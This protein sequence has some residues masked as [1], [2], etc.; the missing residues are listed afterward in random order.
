MVKHATDDILELDRAKHTNIWYPHSEYVDFDKYPLQKEEIGTNVSLRYRNMYLIDRSPEEMGPVDE[1]D[2]DPN[3]VYENEFLILRCDAEEPYRM[4]AISLDYSIILV[5][6]SRY[7]KNEP[8]NARDLTEQQIVQY[9]IQF[10]EFI[11]IDVFND[12]GDKFREGVTI[13]VD[14]GEPCH[15]VIMEFITESRVRFVLGDE[16]PTHMSRYWYTIDINGHT[17]PDN[18]LRTMDVDGGPTDYG[19]MPYIIYDGGMADMM[20]R[21][22]NRN[23]DA[24]DIEELRE[25][26]VS[27]REIIHDWIEIEGNTE[28][29]FEEPI[30]K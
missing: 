29:P 9:P 1:I 24:H 25:H 6:D 2:E 23:L 16:V 28:E 27:E 30:L 20:R 19:T 12:Y 15:T 5:C 8:P 22:Y 3:F 11:G 7:Y 18:I 17:A 13:R 10:D 14:N 21:V 4:I 26:I